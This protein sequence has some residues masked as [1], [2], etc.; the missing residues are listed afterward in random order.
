[1]KIKA[2]KIENTQGIDL[3]FLPFAARN[4]HISPNIDDYVIFQTIIC[5]SDLPNRNGI[6]FPLNELARFTETPNPHFVYKGWVGCPIFIEHC[7]PGNTLIRAQ[8]GLKKITDIKVGDYVLTHANRYKRVK[9]VFSNGEKKL[10][11][12]DA[13]GLVRPLQLTKNHKVFVVGRGQ[14]YESI[15]TMKDHNLHPTSVKAHWRLP[16]DIYPADYLVFPIDI[17]GDISVSTEFAF[18][19]GAYMAEGNIQPSNTSDNPYAAVLTI[20][21]AEKP[22]REA[23]LKCCERLGYSTKV[24]FQKLKGTCTITIKSKEFAIEAKHLCGCYSHKKSMRNELRKWN[25]KAMKAFLGGYLTGDGCNNGTR[26]RCDTVSVNLAQDLQMAFGF[27]NCPAAGNGRGWREQFTD[28]HITRR[29]TIRKNK[30]GKPWRETHDVYWIS[31]LTEDAEEAGLIKY[32][33]GHKKKS[34]RKR[35]AQCETRVRKFGNYLLFPISHIINNVGKDN[36]Y[37]LEVEDD[38]SYVANGVVVHNCN[39]DPTKAIGVI[40]DTSLV[41]CSE[42]YGNGKLYNVIG[43]IAVDKTKDPEMADRFASGGI[44]TVSMGALASY[45]TCSICGAVID[46]EHTCPHIQ[47]KDVVNF[48]PIEDAEGN[49]HIA[50][51]NAHCLEP[52]ET[53]IVKDP[54]WAPALSDTILQK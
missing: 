19:I 12:I 51:L 18:L 34:S 30:G 22:F 54:A 24:S 42:D 16:T 28:K 7:V 20:G 6:A 50:Y 5:P 40:L 37:N 27:I 52:I 41:K 29:N 31:I 21:Y 48:N 23:I 46:D 8:D 47:S 4:Y 13:L 10:M 25:K 32:L 38:N 44:D 14:L 43:V 9:R 36:V 45:F 1:M 17:G 2:E 35:I 39:E 3:S 26:I 49:I 53:S 11:E 15:H 33:V